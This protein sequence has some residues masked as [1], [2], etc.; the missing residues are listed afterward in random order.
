[1]D[2]IYN[3]NH[4]TIDVLRH[5]HSTVYVTIKLTYFLRY[6]SRGSKHAASAGGF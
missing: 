4:L 2:F 3:F 6:Y 1:M 5:G